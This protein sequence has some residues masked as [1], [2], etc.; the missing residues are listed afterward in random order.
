MYLFQGLDPYAVFVKDRAEYFD[1]ASYPATHKCYDPQNNKVIGKFKDEAN[2]EQIVEFVGLRPKMY[3]YSLKRHMSNQPG[4][5]HKAK[6]I[7]Y[8]I[9]AKLKHEDYRK[10]LE[11]P[12][13]NLLKIDELGRNFINC[14]R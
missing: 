1:F 11:A 9:T 4:E 10:Q 14:I 8:A 5:K 7:Q 12:E 13:E 2:G 6:G 3:S